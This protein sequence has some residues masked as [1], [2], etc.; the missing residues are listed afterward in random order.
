LQQVHNLARRM[1]KNRLIEFMTL[2]GYAQL[3]IEHGRS[4]SGVKALEY[5]LAVGRRAGYRHFLWWRPTVAARLCAQALAADIEPDYVRSLIKARALRPDPSSLDVKG[6]P[7]AFQVFTLGRFRLLKD[8]K[9][10]EFPSKAQHRPMELL[11]VLVACGGEEVAEARITDAL[12]PRIDGDSAHRSF[13][14][15]LHRLR[16]LLG[17]DKALVLRDGRLSLDRRY[18]WVDT[19]AFEH[20]TEAMGP[21]SHGASA[22]SSPEHVSAA[23]ARILALYRGPFMGEDMNEA[24]CLAMRDRLRSRFVRCI[25]ELG[26]FWERSSDWDQ[27]IACYQRSLEGD[28]LAEALCRSLMLCS[29]RS[30]RRAEALEAYNRL[31]KLLASTLGIDPS[32]ET[33]A[34]YEQ[35]LQDGK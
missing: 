14:T 12:W 31:R 1:A 21:V 26:G 4:R 5:A 16:K 22:T 15:T 29:Q 27:A 17:E 8:D 25:A 20:A 18:W 10:F 9:P 13:N 33:R 3:A 7:W 6:W 19:W 11:Q 30:G 23:T 34:L 24:W 2:L 35:L 32:A 28:P